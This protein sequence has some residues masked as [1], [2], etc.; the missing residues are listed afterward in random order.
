MTSEAPCAYGV[1]CE[2]LAKILMQHLVQTHHLR[3]QLPT[4]PTDLQLQLLGLS[5]ALNKLHSWLELSPAFFTEEHVT[6]LQACLDDCSLV[7]AEFGKELGGLN[8]V[9]T[10]KH[11]TKDLG[12]IFRAYELKFHPH[13]LSFYIYLRAVRW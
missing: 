1:D 13:V 7:A 4:Y 2:Q 11:E 12:E 8:A 9:C 6:T 3:D 5:Q 10:G